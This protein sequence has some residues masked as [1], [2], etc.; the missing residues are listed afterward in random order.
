VKKFDLAYSVE[1]RSGYPFSIFTQERRLVEEPN[2][3]RF[4]SFFSLNLHAERRVR[5]LSLNLALRGGFNNITNR[6]NAFAVDNN[7]NSSQFLRFSGIQG[8]VFTARIRFL[9]RK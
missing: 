1:W 6:Q 4:P 8:R 9:G 2:S 5:L 3:R 7:V